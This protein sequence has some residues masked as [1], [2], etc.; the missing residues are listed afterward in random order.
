M[1]L[2]FLVGLLAV[3]A[4]DQPNL[5]GDPIANHNAGNDT[6]TTK[7]KKKETPAPG[8]DTPAPPSSPAPPPAP[9]ADQ[10]PT[11]TSVAPDS[12]TVGTSTDGV[13][14]TLNGTNFPSTAQ[15]NL[16]NDK[17]PASFMSPSQLKVRIPADKL[18]TTGM[19]RL[20]VMGKSAE[21][22]ALTF[23][24]ANP[25]STSI[26]TVTPAN[27]LVG[28]SD[29]VALKVTGTGFVAQSVV[30]FNGAAL[31]TT[32]TSAT[33]L[34]ASV[35]AS[36]ILDAGRVSIT[37]A[38]GTDVMSL[39]FAFEI[40]NPTPTA[41]T[42]N[43][44]SVASGAAA[45][46]T[47]TGTGF[48]KGSSVLAG[49]QAV[50]TTF[51]SATTL[52]ALVPANLLAASGNVNVSVQ[53]GTPGGGTSGTVALAI[54]AAGSSSSSGGQQGNAA[55]TYSCKDYN[56]APGQC[57]AG[58][59]CI[60]TGTYAGCLGQA[61][62]GDENQGA[63]GAGGNGA[64]AGAADCTYRCSDYGYDKGECSDDWYCIASGTYAGCLTQAL[65]GD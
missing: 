33:E 48:S 56:Y 38:L 40:R 4:C 51:V 43:P 37:V 21:S 20:T 34:S 24:V 44:A 65:C 54:A 9:Q 60:T 27:V 6:D 49:G 17:I 3:S 19:L 57:Y 23:T 14:V 41:S 28:V 59:Y 13:D 31:A 2:F 63:G 64:G 53:N 32:F 47:V 26:A 5:A 39:P 15:V 35:P 30:K 1:R 45:T 50:S 10:P 42:L 25:T 7:K 12:I 55:C 8:T 62:C 58:Y 22:N 36:A 61:D 11:L 52:R 16:G 46:I 18:K 29:P